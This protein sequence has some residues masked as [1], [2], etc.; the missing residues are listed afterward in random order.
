MNDNPA[1]LHTAVRSCHNWLSHPHVP[2]PLCRGEEATDSTS[3]KCKGMGAT[4]IFRGHRSDC[5]KSIFI[6]SPKI[7]SLLTGGIEYAVPLTLWEVQDSEGPSK[8]WNSRYMYML[9]GL[10]P[11]TWVWVQITNYRNEKIHKK[12]R[13]TRT[14]IWILFSLII[15]KIFVVAIFNVRLVFSP[16]F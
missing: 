5:A 12:D 16:L 6:L 7:Q 14:L 2:S 3:T 11:P 4:A 9:S 1:T 13:R 8:Y 10:L 15:S